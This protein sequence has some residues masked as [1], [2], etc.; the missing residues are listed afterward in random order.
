[1]NVIVIP[2]AKRR[3]ITSWRAELLLASQGLLHGVTES[4]ASLPVFDRIVG[5]FEREVDK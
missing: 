2:S 5:T 1:M 3:S 4:F